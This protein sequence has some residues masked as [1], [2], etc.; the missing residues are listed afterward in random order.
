MQISLNETESVYLIYYKRIIRPFLS[1]ECGSV[2]LV[3]GV[4][5]KKPQ[6]CEVNSLSS[7]DQ[8]KLLKYNLNQNPGSK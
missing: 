2:N 5:R 6:R 7:S 1:E 3:L 4:G 8:G